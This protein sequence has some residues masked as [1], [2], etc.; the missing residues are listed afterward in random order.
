[1]TLSHTS[2]HLT[3]SD[4]EI[5]QLV[6]SEIKSHNS[7]A[8]YYIIIFSYSLGHEK[9]KKKEKK[10]FSSG[11]SC[12]VGSVGCFLF[13]CFV[14]VFVLFF[15]VAKMTLKK[16]WKFPKKKKKKKKIKNIKLFLAE[17]LKVLGK[18][19]D[20][21]SKKFSQSF[22]SWSKNGWFYTILEKLEKKICQNGK[23]GSVVPIKQVFVLFLFCFFPPHVHITSFT[24]YMRRDCISDAFHKKLYQ[25]LRN[26]KN[27][28]RY[29][30]HSR[31][32]KVK[33]TLIHK[34][35]I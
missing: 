32:I 28:Q 35:L 21:F 30:P 22:K 23:F 8:K 10:K 3:L 4:S 16:T 19:F 9:K 2:P 11:R 24:N 7:P 27:M 5:R 1:M 13:F 29:Y 25:S 31:S 26:T 12:Q 6:L 18:Y 20:L 33:K 14:F 15:L 17:K 34:M